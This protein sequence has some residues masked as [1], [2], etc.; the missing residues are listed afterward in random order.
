MFTAKVKTKEELQQ[1]IQVTVEFSDGQK[2]FE[3]TVIPQDKTGF[4]HW[5]RSR[6]SSLNTIETIKTD[7]PDDSEVGAEE[8]PPTKTQAQLDEEQWFEDYYRFV[9]VKA[10]LVDTGIVDID[11]AK[12][13]ALLS[14]V[15]SGLKASYVDKI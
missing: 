12:V 1:G 2:T 7:Y 15:Q 13:Q 8:V 4:E 6:L 3:E 9:R 11:N 14:D 10:T 5:V